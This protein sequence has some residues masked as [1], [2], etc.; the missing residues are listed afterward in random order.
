VGKD[1]Y[2]QC[3]AIKN[4]E[5][6][7]TKEKNRM[8]TSH[9]SLWLRKVLLV[10]VIAT[11]LVWG[12]PALLAPPAFLALFGITMPDDPI[13]LRLFG[14]VVSAVGVAYW[15]A[16]RDPIKNIAILKF[17]VIDNALV[18]LTIIVI[19]LTVG[20]SSWFFWLSACMTAFFCIALV[21][22]MPR[23]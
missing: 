17:G 14:A 18:T 8:N 2:K 16:Y 6:I 23:N 19:G 1:T 22:L 11:F 5:I 15:Y 20:V 3:Y 21:W 7:D 10:K 13:F 9:Q 12:L 4:G